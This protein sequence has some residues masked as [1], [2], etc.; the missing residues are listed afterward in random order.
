MLRHLSVFRHSIAQSLIG[1]LLRIVLY[2]DLI[3]SFSLSGIDEGNS[4]F[5]ADFDQVFVIGGLPAVC[6][7]ICFN[8]HS[9]ICRLLCGSF[10]CLFCRSFCCLLCCICSLFLY[11]LLCCCSP[12]SFLLCIGSGLSAA[13]RCHQDSDQS[14]SNQNSTLHFSNL[15]SRRE[16]RINLKISLQADIRAMRE[17]STHLLYRI[18]EADC[19]ISST[20]AILSSFSAVR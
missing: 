15:R 20:T 14:H 19:R 4:V 1:H 10:C 13:S 5:F 7:L 12:G 17:T 11:V 16:S 9:N 2:L 6:T 18:Q 3:C 8:L